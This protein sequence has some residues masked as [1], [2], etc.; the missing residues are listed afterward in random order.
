[1]DIQAYTMLLL[2]M[3]KFRSHLS[4][5]VISTDLHPRKITV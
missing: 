2:E 3:A 4:E 1:M 5:C